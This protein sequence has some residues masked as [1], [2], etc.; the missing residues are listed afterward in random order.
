MKPQWKLFL[1][2]NH[3]DFQGG[4]YCPKSVKS[5]HEICLYVWNASITCSMCIFSI[6]TITLHIARLVHSLSCSSKLSNLKGALFSHSFVSNSW[7]PHG[8]Q[9][10]KLSCPSL[11]PGVC[12]DSCPL[13]R[14]C[15]PTI[16]SS[17][18]SFSSCPQSFPASGSFPTTWLFASGGQ[19]IGALA[20]ASVL[21]M[22]IQDWF[23]LDWT[24]RISLQ[25]K[26]YS[27]VFSNTT[28]QKH[29]FYGA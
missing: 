23:P 22:N 4:W 26:G 2:G 9:H 5:G 16:S 14:W 28:V 24:D 11:F 8:L 25:S 12:S 15:H 19:G 1:V 18:T 13:S 27:R 17:V 21:P 3:T 7:Q 10:S 29:Q 20:S 6:K